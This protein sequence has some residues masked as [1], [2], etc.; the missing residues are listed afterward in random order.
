MN[1]LEIIKYFNELDDI[2]IALIII[3]SILFIITS[4][5]IVKFVFFDKYNIESEMQKYINE[6][7]KKTK[8][9]NYKK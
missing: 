9:Y 2:D 6:F 7:N 8:T 3:I 5:V 1:F 4:L